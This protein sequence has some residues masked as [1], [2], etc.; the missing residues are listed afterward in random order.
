MMEM[1]KLVRDNI[2]NIIKNQGNKALTHVA[3]E[4][5]FHSRLKDKLMEE[6]R[7]FL[8]DENV[9][10]LADILE[11]LY[12]LCDSMGIQR[13]E[14]EKTRCIKKAQKGAFQKRIVLERVSLNHKR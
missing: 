13:D 3:N 11:V 1:N 8:E 4:K 9:E 14:L 7:E 10:E 6:V 12:A 5:E 2:P